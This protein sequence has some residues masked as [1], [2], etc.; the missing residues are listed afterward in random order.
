M[1]IVDCFFVKL[2]RF[3]TEKLN[4][5]IS[6]EFSCISIFSIFPS[7]N[8][9]CLN[10]FLYWFFDFQFGRTQVYESTQLKDIPVLVFYILIVI[11]NSKKYLPNG[12]IKDLLIK[13]KEGCCSEKEFMFLLYLA[14][15]LVGLVLDFLFF[16]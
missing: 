4:G 11:W 9:L 1:G 13:E 3:Y 16:F 7:I 2:Y 10:N 6:P 14:G 12:V 8:L 5:Y 15:T